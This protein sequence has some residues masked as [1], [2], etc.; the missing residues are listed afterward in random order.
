MSASPSAVVS[1]EVSSPSAAECDPGESNG[2]GDA[3]RR[4]EPATEGVSQPAGVAGA[5]VDPLAGVPNLF[6]KRRSA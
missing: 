6:A 2:H 1:W 5:A 3:A 4:G